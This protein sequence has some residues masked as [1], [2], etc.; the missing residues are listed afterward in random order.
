LSWNNYPQVRQESPACGGHF[1]EI[2]CRAD[3]FCLPNTAWTS[4]QHRFGMQKL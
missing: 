1:R 4:R 2:F 3:E